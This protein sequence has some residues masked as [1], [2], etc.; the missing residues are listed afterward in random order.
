MI[1]S[2]LKHM[3]ERYRVEGV[4]CLLYSISWRMPRWLFQYSHAY[5]VTA[6]DLEV[7]APPT[8]IFKFRLAGPC[9][10][11]KFASL[12]L[13]VLAVNERFAS[14]D[15]CGIAERKDGS[16]C[17]MVWVSTG[18]LYLDT[19]GAVLD[20]DPEGV[21]FYNAF[22]LAQD[23]G[24]GLYRGCCSV[25]C[26]WFRR[27]G[28][29]ARYG[30]IDKLNYTSIVAHGRMNLKPTGEARHFHILFFWITQLANWP[31]S[32]RRLIVSIGKHTHGARV[33]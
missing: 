21:Y 20:V 30:L 5:L 29:S 2:R 15:I 11:E 3:R 19:A 16:M 12:G 23:R 8:E 27:Q 17:S 26:D 31:K 7:T 33:V 24:L 32:R 6:H 9:D 1:S 22:T 18:R 25:Y 14:G 10:A 28:R 4:D 13:S